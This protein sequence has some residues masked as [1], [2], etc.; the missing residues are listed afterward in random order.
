MARTVLWLGGMSG[1]GKTTAARRV[2]RRLDLWLY[3]IDARTYAHAEAMQVPAL[4][5]TVDELWLDR[6]PEQMAQ[7]FLDEADAR[8]PLIQAEVSAIPEDG[9]PILVEG[10]QLPLGLEPALYVVASPVLQ[11]ELLAGRGSFTYS[12]TRDPGR[13]FANRVRRDEILREWLLPHAIEI[14][15]VGQT[16]RILES[17]VREHATLPRGGDVAARRRYDNDAAV[18]QWR[19]YAEREPRARDVTFD[20]ACECDRPGCEA[21]VSVSFDRTIQ[22][23]FLSH[24]G[25]VG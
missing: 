14:E 15:D 3:S 10:P 25:T 16:E 20:F 24:G 9:A 17:F 4:T 12:S 5:M 22:R 18:D 11:Q 6:S 19:R 8:F 23:P 13:A 2:A 21:L 7:E 1:V